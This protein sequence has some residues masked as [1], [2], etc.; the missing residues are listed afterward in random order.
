MRRRLRAFPA[1]TA[2]VGVGWGPFGVAEIRSGPAFAAA[3]PGRVERA[4]RGDT[5][6]TAVVVVVASAIESQIER[7]AHLVAGIRIFAR[8][9]AVRIPNPVED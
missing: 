9:A 1:R 5:A 7:F 6:F 4:A 8:G 3:V 2:I